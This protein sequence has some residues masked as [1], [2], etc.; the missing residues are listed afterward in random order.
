MAPLDEREV[1]QREDP[2]LGLRLEIHEDV[3]AADQVEPGERRVRQQVLPCE[4]HRLTQLLAD[5][6]AVPLVDE[7]PAAPLRRHVGDDA[8]RVEAGAAH[9]ERARIHVR[10]EDLDGAALRRGFPLLDEEHGDG[11]GLLAGRAAGHPHAERCMGF[12]ACN[13]RTNHLLLQNPPCLGVA[14]EARDAD[15]QIV[16][17]RRGL[18]RILPSGV[19]RSRPRARCASSPCGGRCDARACFA[20]SCGSRTSSDRA[21]PPGRRPERSRSMCSAAGRPVGPRA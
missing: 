20:C 5:P 8:L 17:Q 3:A 12:L 7:E 11:V 21:G 6:K 18:R 1:Q 15:Q 10:R 4:H 16:A 14:E 2:P 9:L 19:A 13:Q